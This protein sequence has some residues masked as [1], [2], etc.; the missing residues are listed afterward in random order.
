MVV[1]LKLLSDGLPHWIY[2][3]NDNE[4][5]HSI[6]EHLLKLFHIN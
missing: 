2:F 1:L 3:V 5:L 6:F 4:W